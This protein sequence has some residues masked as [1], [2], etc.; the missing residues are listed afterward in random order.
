MFSQGQII[1]AS[2]FIVAFVIIMII[3]Y[4]K[5]LQLHKFYYKG[6]LWV[7]LAFLGF[8]GFLF[9]IKATLKH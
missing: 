1:F 7:L 3:M 5:D 8:V 6:S 9:I 2:I 4:K